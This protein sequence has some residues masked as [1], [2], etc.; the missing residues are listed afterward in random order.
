MQLKIRDASGD[1]SGA[2]DPVTVCLLQN[3][4]QQKALCS[5]KTEL[6]TLTYFFL[7]NLRELCLTAGEK[8]EHDI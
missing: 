4:S 7:T 1:F 3:Q 5:Q 2:L 6:L 8:F